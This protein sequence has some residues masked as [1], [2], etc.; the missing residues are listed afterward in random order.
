MTEVAF[1]DIRFPKIPDNISKELKEY[2]IEFERRLINASIGEFTTGGNLATDVDHGEL[3]G[4]SDDDHPQYHNDARGDARYFR[5]NE[6]LNS[7]AGAGDAGKPIKL[8]A[9][10]KVD[11][12]MINDADID[13]GSIGGLSDN[14]HPQYIKKDGTTSDISANI[15]LNTHKLTGVADPDAAQDAATK[16]Y[17]DNALGNAPSKRLYLGS[18]QVDIDYPGWVIVEIDTDSAGFD[19][20]SSAD[21]DGNKITPGTAGFYLLIAQARLS[22][23]MV[24]SDKEIW[25]QITVNGNA[26][27]ETMAHDDGHD[28]YAWIQASA[29]V[30]LDSDDYVQMAVSQYAGGSIDIDD[31]SAITFLAVQRVR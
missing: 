19:T 18:Q 21:K 28:E 30:K 11:D 12:T 24:G 15:P 2:L 3:L 23:F 20:C 22:N 26:V 17:V 13:H 16:N 31:G 6:H 27:A 8:D 25:L 10:G 7:S 4:L 14:D 9:G 5:E 29:I 1:R